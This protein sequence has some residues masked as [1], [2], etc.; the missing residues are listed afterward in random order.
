[1]ENT[2]E[3]DSSIINCEADKEH[4][5]KSMENGHDEVIV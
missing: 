3:S 4:V 5:I 1:M 2:V